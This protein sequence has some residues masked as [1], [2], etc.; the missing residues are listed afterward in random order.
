[1]NDDQS[2]K[3]EIDCKDFEIGEISE[4]NQDEEEVSNFFTLSIV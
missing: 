4:I 2:I 1:M 3:Y